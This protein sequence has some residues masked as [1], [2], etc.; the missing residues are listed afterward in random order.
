VPAEFVPHLFDRYTRASQTAGAAKG[1]GLGLFI[2]SQLVQVNEG[3]I[4]Y[5]PGSPGGACFVVR[6]PAA[7]ASAPADEPVREEAGARRG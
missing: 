7:P 5:R 1:T 3:E 2:V 6:L 4:S